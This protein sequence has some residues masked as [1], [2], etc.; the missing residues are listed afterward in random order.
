[1]LPT[2]SLFTIKTEGTKEERS[3]FTLDLHRVENPVINAP[4]LHYPIQLKIIFHKMI[5][6]IIS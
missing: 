3:R 2:I 1:M 4:I 5:I 6:K